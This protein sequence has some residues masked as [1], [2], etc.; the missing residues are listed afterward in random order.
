MDS[1]VEQALAQWVPSVAPE[2]TADPLWQLH[3]YRVARYLVDQSQRDSAVLAPHVDPKTVA[4]LSRAVASIGANIAE[5]YSR[6]S[7]ADR[8]RFYGYALGATREAMVWYRSV[9]WCLDAES[10]SLRMA[11]LAQ[12]RRLLLG[13]LKSVQRQGMPPFEQGL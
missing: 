2:E 4:Q 12:Q 6:R 10:I 13:I 9:A 11:F 7:S 3:A 1:I 8:A 5:G